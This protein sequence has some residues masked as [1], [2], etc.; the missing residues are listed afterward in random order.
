MSVDNTERKGSDLI[1]GNLNLALLMFFRVLKLV[2]SVRQLR[3]LVKMEVES[4]SILS[5]C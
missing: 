1:T 3:T 5:L 4:L 2:E